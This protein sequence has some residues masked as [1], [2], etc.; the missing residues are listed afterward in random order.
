MNQLSVV[1]LNFN[2]Q[3]YL[4]QFLPTVLQC[5]SGHEV[6]VA[7]NASTDDSVKLMREEFP[8]VRLL[9]F[10]ENHGYSGGY[11][12]AIARI[13]SR[14][15]VL[16]NSDVEVTP[17]WIEPVLEVLEADEDIA[18]AQ[19][20]IR[21][22]KDKPLFEYAGAS[23]GF[24]DQL[25]YPFCRGRIF[26]TIETDEGQYEDTREVF[27]ASGSALFVRR[28]CYLEAGGL[29]EDF[30]AHMEEIDLCWRFWNMGKKV[31]VCPKSTIFHV[32]GGTLHKSHPRKTYLNFRN[33]LSLLLKNEKTTALW[34]K[35]PLRLLLDW[36]AAAHFSFYS[37]IKHAAAIFRAHL[38]F[39]GSF[40]IHVKKRQKVMNR[41]TKLPRYR[42]LIIWQ[43]FAKGRKHYSQVPNR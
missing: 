26:H 11:N 39:F 2:G 27:W 3:D 30:F 14:Y 32:G 25:A 37:G 10:D 9:Q 22:Y 33:G 20:K 35:L 15:I 12:E 38:H 28:E 41:R 31:M 19:P 8:E 23:G 34:W 29:D 6:V 24:I 5:S 43:Y 40:F 1:I 4:R 21:D 7:D 16:L 36:A 42:G 18:A 13:E 17:D